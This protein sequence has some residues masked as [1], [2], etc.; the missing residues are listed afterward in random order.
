MGYVS[1]LRGEKGEKGGVSTLGELRVVNYCC[2]YLFVCV[3]MCVCKY[4][5]RGGGKGKMEISILGELRLRKY[6][7]Y[8]C[9]C[10]YICRGVLGGYVFSLRGKKR[11]K[12]ELVYV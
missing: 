8:S 7:V 2:F 12:G 10:V 9:V 11:E 5:T 4:A 1:T 3:C 6:C